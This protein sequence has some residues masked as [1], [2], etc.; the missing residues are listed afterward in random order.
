MVYNR[1]GVTLKDL[2]E[3]HKSYEPS[4]NTELITKA[5]NFAEAAHVG[6]KRLSGEGMLEHVSEV[7][8]ILTEVQADS[9]TIAAALLHDVLEKTNLEQE[10]LAEEFGGEIT[11]LVEGLRAVKEAGSHVTA[12]EERDWENLRHMML[13]SIKDPRVLMIRLAEK[14]HNLRTISAL[15]PERQKTSAQKVFDIW[16]PLA[17]ILGLYRFKAEL[18]DR[19]FSILEPEKYKE[20]EEKVRAQAG[21]MERVVETVKEKLTEALQKEGIVGEMKGRTKHL[22]G[23][24]RKLPRYQEKAGGMFYDLLGFRVVVATV[25]ECYRVLDIIRRLWREVPGLFDDYIAHPKPNGYQ[26]LQDVFEIDSHLVEI[27]IRTKTMEEFAEY[28]LAAHQHYATLEG[29]KK[30][31]G[32]LPASEAKVAL[33]KSLAFWEKGQELNLFPNEVF[34]FTPKGDV[35]VLPKGATPIDFA[36]AVHTDLGK[37]C[38]GAKVNEKMISLNYQLQNGEVVEIIT[39]R[40]RKPSS[41]WLAFVK[42]E[43]ARSQI[44]KSLKS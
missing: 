5:Y 32:S 13:A 39:G 28:G 44:Q 18:E 38:S 17:A 1:V 31:E 2:L 34:V 15:P 27:Q 29:E 12:E 37:N 40:G 4:L 23:V 19:A 6:Q 14:I 42:T 22:Y 41:D 25:E 3:K 16:S 43:L 20:I 21:E 33:I 10:A 9:T 8:G 36:F 35:K 30:R 7:A 26:S 24:Y 11:S